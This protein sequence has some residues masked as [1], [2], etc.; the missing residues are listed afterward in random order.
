MSVTA[1]IGAS[2]FKPDAVLDQLGGSEVRNH[3]HAGLATQYAN[4]EGAGL[5]E[6]VEPMCTITPLVRS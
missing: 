1:T 3:L 4:C 6:A 2:A 5:Y